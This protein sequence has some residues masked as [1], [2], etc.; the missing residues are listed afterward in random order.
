MVQYADVFAKDSDD[1][2]Q[3]HLLEHPI[4]T[5][6]AAP[7]AEPPRRVPLAFAEA[8]KNEI[9]KLLKCGL[10]HPSSSPWVSPLC[11]VKKPDGTTRVC[12]DY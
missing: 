7:I 11:L 3:T 1:I 2:G 9:E 5:G 10:I 8:E 4:D 6:N 12:I